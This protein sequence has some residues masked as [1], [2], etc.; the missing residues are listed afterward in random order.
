MADLSV[1]IPALNEERAL[2][3]L[4]DD[5]H[6]QVGIEL[7]IV[8]ADGG[9]D[10]A[11]CALTRR[12]GARLVNGVS[13]RAR[14]MNLGAEHAL[15]PALLFLHADTRIE[16]AQLLKRSLEAFRLE[17]S[18]SETPVAGH[19][20]LQ[21][22][23]PDRGS[24]R[25]RYLERKTE[26][27]RPGTTNGD[28]GIM[29]LT[30]TFDMLG[31]FD[32]ELPFLED[33][34]FACEVRERARW[35]TLPG[36]LTASSRRF[37]AEGFGR[38]YLLMAV[39]MGAFSAGVDEFFLD[40]PELYVRHD[41]TARLDLAPY[42]EHIR[43]VTREMGPKRGLEA[44]FLVGRFIR[45]NAWQIPFALDVL[46]EGE[47]EGAPVTDW[48]DEHIAPKIEGPGWDALLMVLSA[49]AFMFVIPAIHGVKRVLSR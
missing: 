37:E 18:R 35:F 19:F 31:G 43:Q 40:A 46:F 25:Y 26:L 27:N 47:V 49:E 39:I 13:G 10:D 2:P 20:A 14:Q 11:T 9:S 41:H 6:Q 7:D 38:R 28:Q 17:S 5:L 15:A 3:A 22:D 33:Q 23:A 30:S 21:F 29:V 44:W 34:R 45:Q 42:F 4:L 48:F 12:R 8:V 32:P 36:R 1:I 16:D 24:F